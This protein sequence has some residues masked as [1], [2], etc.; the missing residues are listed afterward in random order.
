MSPLWIPYANL[1]PSTFQCVD[2]NEVSAI[3]LIVTLLMATLCTLG[4]AFYARFL[5]ALCKERRH[6]RICLLVCLQTQP[7]RHAISDGHLLNKPIRHAA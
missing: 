7:L 2:E 5:F 3:A 4:V 6:Q 1:I